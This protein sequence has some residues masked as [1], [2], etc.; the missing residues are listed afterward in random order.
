MGQIQLAHEN[1][2]IRRNFKY[3]IAQDRHGFTTKPMECHQIFILSTG[4]KEDADDRIL[5]IIEDPSSIRRKRTRDLYPPKVDPFFTYIAGAA[6]LF[7]LQVLY[8]FL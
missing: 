5:T 8:A 6:S 4:T 3:I 1:R 7:G 2:L